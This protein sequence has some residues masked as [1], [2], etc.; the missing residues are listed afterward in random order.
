M[1][2]SEVPTATA[3]KL[4]FQ[5]QFQ[6]Q[7]DQLDTLVLVLPHSIP[8]AKVADPIN[9]VFHRIPDSKSADER[10]EV[11]NRRMDILYG[12]HLRQEDGSLPNILRGPHGIPKV[13]AYLKECKDIPLEQ[14]EWEAATNKVVRIFREVQQ[15]MYVYFIL[16]G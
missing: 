14:F 12:E 2:D 5:E 8:F 1:S 7:V 6:R 11:F 13:L 16:S 3:R 10:W 15:L 4:R 9:T